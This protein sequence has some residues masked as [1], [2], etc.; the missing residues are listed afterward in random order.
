MNRTPC[1]G[2]VAHAEVPPTSGFDRFVG[3]LPGMRVG[4]HK[5]N[6]LVLLGYVVISLVAV[7]TFLRLF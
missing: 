6:A 2:P 7:G 1:E 4:A 5:R 3:V